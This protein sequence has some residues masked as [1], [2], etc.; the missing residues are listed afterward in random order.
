M[1]WCG[2]A[3]VLKEQKRGKLL[4][5]ADRIFGIRDGS[6]DERIEKG[7]QAMQD[8]FKSLGLATSLSEKGVGMDTIE[9][10][11]K[12]FDA[13]AKP[14]G[15]AKNVDGAMTRKILLACL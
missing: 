1:V 3:R 8:W 10:I 6:E 4:Q 9:F 11:A 15:E 2:L 7:I 13:Y 5:M 14:Y 12:R